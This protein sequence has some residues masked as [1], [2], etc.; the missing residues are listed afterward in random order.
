M[1][2]IKRQVRMIMMM[3]M[4]MVI[5]VMSRDNDDKDESEYNNDVVDDSDEYVNG[6]K[7]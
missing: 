1:M 2:T 5:K 6:H 4:N 3:V 7:S